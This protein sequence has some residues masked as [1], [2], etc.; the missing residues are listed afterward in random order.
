MRAHYLIDQTGGSRLPGAYHACGQHQR[1]GLQWSALANTARAATEARVDAQFDFRKTKARSRYI[2]C[3][4]II[5]GQ[6]Q[7]QSTAQAEA[8]D[9]DHGGK[10]EVFDAVEQLVGLSNMVGRLFSIIDIAEFPDIRAHDE[11]P[12][13]ARLQHQALGRGGFQVVN[14]VAQLKHH[15]V[16]EAVLPL[17]GAIEREPSHLVHIVFKAPMP[18]I[19]LCHAELQ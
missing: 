3:D 7:F 9:G 19:L 13:L 2:L 8:L 18:Q 10:I 11:R 4:P 17:V 6:R 14:D 1:H 12:G 15:L 16:R 5:E